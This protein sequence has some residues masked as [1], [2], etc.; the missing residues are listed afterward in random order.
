MDRSIVF[1]LDR[2]GSMESIRDDTIGGFNACMNDQKAIGGNL[3]LFQFDHEIVETYT[4]V[5]LNEVVP[6]TRETY[7]PRGSTALLDAIG[8]VI[9][10]WTGSESP[11]VIILTDGLENQSHKYTKAHVKDLI[12]Q[13]TKDG[14]TF[15]YLGA[16]EDAFSEAGG[17]GISSHNTVQ[18]D[19]LQTPQM[20]NHLSQT[21]SHGI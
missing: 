3:T 13:K 10:T 14:W 19:A 12:E 4:R 2:S 7:V 6:L 18:Y 21:L 16:H 20:F 5:N 9:K 17:L 1:L 15:V 8:H 11:T